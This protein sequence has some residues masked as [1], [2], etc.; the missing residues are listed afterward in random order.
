MTD[1][2][3]RRGCSK[4]QPRHPGGGGRPTKRGSEG[5]RRTAVCF[6]LSPS[7]GRKT[8]SDLEDSAT[9]PVGNGGGEEGTASEFALCDLPFALCFW[10][11][12][13]A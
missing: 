5:V 11:I 10:T 9:S 6:E 3:L 8:P 1:D 13:H 4:Q 2:G 12:P 7:S